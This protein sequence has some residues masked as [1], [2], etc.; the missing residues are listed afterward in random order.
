MSEITTAVSDEEVVE[1]M[2]SFLLPYIKDFQIG[3]NIDAPLPSPPQLND[4]AVMSKL[5]DTLD[6]IVEVI[7][8]KEVGIHCMSAFEISKSNAFFMNPSRI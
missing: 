3:E 8:R 1:H 6:S 4:T 5:C 2:R 7:P